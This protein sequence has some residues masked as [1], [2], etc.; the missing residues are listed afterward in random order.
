MNW[1]VQF[2][3][4]MVH[5][6]VI[7]CPHFSAENAFEAKTEWQCIYKYRK[8]I[9]PPIHFTTLKVVILLFFS[10]YTLLSFV[11]NVSSSQ[12]TLHTTGLG[13]QI[14]YLTCW[15]S[16]G[17]CFSQIMSLSFKHSNH[18]SSEQAPIFPFWPYV[19][20]LHELSASGKSRWKL[21]SVSCYAFSILKHFV[22]NLSHHDCCF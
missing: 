16:L 10:Q 12:N 19:D 6:D 3:S 13:L 21:C 11:T 2:T 17:Q 4:N 8:I 14:R 9:I 5:I 1:F 22:L 7:W 20:K 18:N 15:W